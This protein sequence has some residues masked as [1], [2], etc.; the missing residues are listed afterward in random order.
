VTDRIDH[1]AHRIAWAGTQVSSGEKIPG[2]GSWEI[3]DHEGCRGHGVLQALGRGDTGPSCP[4]CGATVRW[5]LTHLAPSVAAD[6][7][8]VGRLP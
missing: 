1:G 3:V 7:K 5:Q 6:H 8:G 4:A 2:A